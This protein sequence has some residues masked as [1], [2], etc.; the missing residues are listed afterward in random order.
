MSAKTFPILF[1]APPDPV[2]AI[3][4]SGAIRR[5]MEEIPSAR[6]TVVGSEG[7]APLFAEIPDLA[8]LITLKKVDKMGVWLKTRTR[9]WGL[10]ADAAGTG[11]AGLL[12]RQRR[13]EWKRAPLPENRVVGY[14]RMLGLADAPPQPFLFTGPEREARADAALAG[15]GPILGVAPGADWVGRVWPSER[16]GQVTA[17]LLLKGGPMAGGR[18]IAFGAEGH[19]DAM[20]TAKFPLPRNRMLLRDYDQDLLT[21][22]AWLK[23]VRLFIG[24]DNI[25]TYLAAAA[26]APTLAIFGPTDEA[27]KAP[28]GDHARVIRG[29]RP[30]EALSAARPEIRPADQPHERP[31]RGGRATG[32]QGV[33]RRHGAE[34]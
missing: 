25:W 5:L 22:Y 33:V 26:G 17:K 18:I 2:D 19:R 28:F 20:L 12:S 13:A 10:V 24:C 31:F 27:V 8:G 7:S 14:G 23:R 4:A 34:P 21:D 1:I 11:V 30:F 16:F 29:P 15:E 3:C 32:G 9:R 6:F